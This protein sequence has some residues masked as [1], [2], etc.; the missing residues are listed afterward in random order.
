LGSSGFG[1]DVDA[2]GFQ[3]RSQFN[4]VFKRVRGE[5]P[6]TWREHTGLH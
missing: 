4:R 2:A 3:S 6:T 1:E 5:Q